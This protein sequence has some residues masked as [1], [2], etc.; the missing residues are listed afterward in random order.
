MTQPHA[1][2]FTPP[3]VRL[4]SLR[5]SYY[6][7]L[8]VQPS[9]SVQQIRQAYR[10]LSR[11]YHPDTT[12]LPAAIAT[13]K[14]KQLNEAYATLSQPERRHQYDVKIGYARLAGVRPNAPGEWR[15]S[16]PP[17]PPVTTAVYL[18]PGHSSTEMVRERPLSAGELFVLF[19]LLLTFGGCLV[20]AI[21]V[22][23]TRETAPLAPIVPAML[24]RLL[25]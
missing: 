12:D 14:F 6:D 13:E 15:R 18:D 22:A 24:G 25:V 2:P 20:L 19:V 7:R 4:A 1:T 11:Q 10:R 3:P 21:V 8:G 16:S 17:A 23:L 5:G 9:A